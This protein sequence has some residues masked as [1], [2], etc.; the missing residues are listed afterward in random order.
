MKRLEEL[1]RGLEEDKKSDLERIENV[2][3]LV[4]MG[5]FEAA[6]SELGKIKKD[7]NIYVGAK[8]IIRDLI[9][10]NTE[11]DRDSI[12]NYLRELIPIINGIGNQ[13]YRA[14]LLFDLAVAFYELGDDFNGDMAL[15]TAINLSYTAGEDVLFE[16]L[17]EVIRR[18]LL[19]KATYAFSLVK[20]RKKIDFLLSQL[21]EFLYLSGDLKKAEKALNKIGEPF[22]RAVTLYRL[23]LVEI[24]RN[25]RDAALKF[26]EEAIKNA[27]KIE[28]KHARLE[29]LIKLNDLTAELTGEE[30]TLSSILKE[31]GSPS[32][33]HGY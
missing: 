14:L 28:N 16:I 33:Q 17:K 26:L 32:S 10:P 12:L 27:E 4:D 22:Y 11:L 21:V 1:F 5:D 8:I 3:S 31:S 23:A 15:K 20:D 29:L 24:E 18:G 2:E 13:R 9:K 6:I 25:N 30:V 7:E 19:E